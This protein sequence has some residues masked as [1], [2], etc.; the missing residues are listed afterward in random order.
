[1]ATPDRRSVLLV[2]DGCAA[3]EATAPFSV[4]TPD[5]I[6][7]ARPERLDSICADDTLN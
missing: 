4:A 2:A 7:P 6:C 3:L 5:F 1:M